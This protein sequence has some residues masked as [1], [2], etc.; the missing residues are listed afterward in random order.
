MSAFVNE[1]PLVYRLTAA[2]VLAW[3]TGQGRLQEA[4][5]YQ[6]FFWDWADAVEKRPATFFADL[7]GSH[8]HTVRTCVDRL[9]ELGLIRVSRGS[10]T[11]Q[12][13]LIFE[14][15]VTKLYVENLYN[16]GVSSGPGNVEKMDQN[17]VR[18]VE[19]FDKLEMRAEI[20]RLPVK[21]EPRGLNPCY[22]MLYD[23]G[24]LFGTVLANTTTNSLTTYVS[25]C[26]NYNYTTTT[27]T[28]M[29]KTSTVENLDQPAAST[30]E[31]DGVKKKSTKRKGTGQRGVPKK[32]FAF[33][34]AT[35]EQIGA[36]EYNARIQKLHAAWN[37]QLG[38][39]YEL[40]GWRY[41]AWRM[42]LV[43]QQ[44]TEEQVLGAIPALKRD[45]W[46]LERFTDPHDM[47]GT[48][49]DRIEK[50]FPGNSKGAPDRLGRS[51]P[52]TEES[53]TF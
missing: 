13:E 30:S 26:I 25:S 3:L 38:L 11:L 23:T 46:S 45:A 17:E 2:A 39:D 12:V 24:K 41:A 15:I 43:D 50:F 51:T 49:P 19:I 47:F 5:I 21:L 36:D 42:A 16:V 1:V 28:G 33:R 32:S 35:K 9:E 52:S 6:R 48:R 20:W 14:G 53:F 7:L 40:T 27:T 44:Y 10:K 29:S 18:D 31:A 34:W 4:V 37:E 8:R 22:V